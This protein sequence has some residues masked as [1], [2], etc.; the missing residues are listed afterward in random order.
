MSNFIKVGGLSLMPLRI[1]KKTV[2]NKRD[3]EKLILMH[4]AWP[5]TKTQD[6]GEKTNAC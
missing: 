5:V 1:N 4:L 6:L 3:G 2:K